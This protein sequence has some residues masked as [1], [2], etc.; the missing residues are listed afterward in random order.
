MPYTNLEQK[1]AKD[2][3]Y[4]AA[5]REEARQK[6]QRWREANRDKHRA[7]AKKYYE[8]HKGTSTGNSTKRSNKL[9]V[10]SVYNISPEQQEHVNEVWNDWRS[11]NLETRQPKEKKARSKFTKNNP[12]YASDYRLVKY[13]ITR[14]IFEKMVEDQGNCCAVCH[15][16]FGFKGLIP[17]VDHDHD[18]GRVRSILHMKCNTALGQVGD[19]LETLNKFVSYLEKHNG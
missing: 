3:E 16:E 1:Q 14:E 13:G 9:Y 5:H 8:E 12:N 7:Y 19:R 2:R 11:K 15:E 6:A 4:A 18:T 10:D 17:V